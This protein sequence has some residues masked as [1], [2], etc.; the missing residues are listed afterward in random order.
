MKPKGL[1]TK[2]G[3]SKFSHWEISL[4]ATMVTLVW[5]GGGSVQGG[6]SPPL[7]MVYGHSNTS[8]GWGGEDPEKLAVATC[9]GPHWFNCVGAS[10]WSAEQHMGCSPQIWYQLRC[11]PSVVFL[12]KG[13]G[14]GGGVLLHKSGLW[15]ANAKYNRHE[16]QP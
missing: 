8:L 15:N 2:N 10:R 4:L 5:A 1:C 14:G 16:T 11:F 12:L 9:S 6:A 3:P 7:P 13:A